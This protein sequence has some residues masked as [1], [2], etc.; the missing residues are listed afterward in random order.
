MW[1][2]T[3]N[4]GQI[5]IAPDYVLCSKIVQERFIHYVDKALKEFFN[6]RAKTT[7]D[8]GRIVSIKHFDR[9]TN[10]LKNQ[11]IAIGGHSDPQDLFIHPTRT[12]RRKS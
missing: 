4:S 6:D 1:G 3:Q 11:K 10:M 5:C 2:K 8:Y 12:D 7:D 9:V